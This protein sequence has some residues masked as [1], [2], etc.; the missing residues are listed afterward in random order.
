MKIN[1]CKLQEVI[2]K[3]KPGISKKKIMEQAGHLIFSN[4]EIATF[5]D[6][7]CIMHPFECEYSFS[8]EESEFTKIL[9]GMTESE[10]ELSYID[11]CIKVKSKST[12]ASL[13]TLI[14]EEAKIEHLVESLK[15]E[16]EE[17][18]FFKPLPKEFI[19]GV[20]LCAFSAN[21]D[22]ATGVRACVAIKG[23]TIASTDNIRVSMYVMDASVEEFLLLPAKAALELI[24]YAVIEYGVTENWAYFRTEDGMIFCCK[25]MKGDYPLALIESVI[26]DVE[27]KMV[28]PDELK[29]MVN[30]IASLA[31]GDLDINKMIKVSVGKGLIVVKAE[32][33][34]G[35]IEK[36]M[37][38]E[39]KGD[40]FSFSIN[41]IFFAQILHHAT[42]FVLLDQKAQ[43]ASENFYHT[44]A[45]PME[46]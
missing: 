21:K 15:K 30:S 41:P 14:G 26:E 10:F 18:N 22:I 20:Y 28:F 17:T 13:S 33:E 32:K 3:V 39:Y 6:Q 19:N 7:I 2:Q 35:W 24:K 5:N 27:S 40:S 4:N 34:R 12:K 42:G 16:S 25:T 1:K 31:E 23:D 45:L 38:F 37:D 8:V 44:M 9:D 46:D 11:D 43:F 36:T 29:E